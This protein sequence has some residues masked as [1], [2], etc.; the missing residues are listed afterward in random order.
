M[1][2]VIALSVLVAVASPAAAQ[3]LEK[4]R[5]QCMGWMM[6]GYPSGIEET[7]CTAQFSLPS[8]FLFKCARAQ[9]LGFD[10]V[11]QRKACKLLFEEAS[12]ATDDGYIRN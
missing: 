12:L 9:R 8:P 3:T 7:A 1:R 10:S 4:R 2:A 5:A 6:N 11:R